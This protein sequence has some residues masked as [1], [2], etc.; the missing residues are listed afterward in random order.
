MSNKE[1][2]SKIIPNVKLGTRFDSDGN[3]IE[4]EIRQDSEATECRKKIIDLLLSA[5]YF[6]VMIKNLSDFD[7]IVG[8]IT[9]CMEACEQNVDVDL[10]FH[11]NLTIGQKIALTERVVKVLPTMKCP[12]V[13]EPH[14][15]QGKD[16]INIFP[17]V[18]WLVKESVKLRSEKAERL[19]AFAVG[20][21]HNHFTVTSD[22]REKA[23]KENMVAMMKKVEDFY[24]AKRQYKR[25]QN[26]EPDDEYSRVRLTLLEYGIKTIAKSISKK[27]QG[28]KLHSI[29][30][31]EEMDIEDDVSIS[32]E[33]FEWLFICSLLFCLH[34]IIFRLTLNN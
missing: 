12:Y 32:V 3:E 2:F 13:L 8:G 29:D 18:Q 21:F 20:Q 6:R 28:Q 23:E 15:I 30:V 9:W 17:V 11:E 22:E 25:K 7:K 14:Q 26:S 24:A 33:K 5:G 10:L 1:K 19:K 27:G 16:F 31:S 34:L 4:V